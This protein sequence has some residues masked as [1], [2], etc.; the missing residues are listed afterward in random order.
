MS[1]ILIYLLQLPII[2]SSPKTKPR[3]DGTPPPCP[4]KQVED[5]LPTK[6]RQKTP[7]SLVRRS[8]FPGRMKQVGLDAPN[9][10]NNAIKLRTSETSQ[11]ADGTPCQV[12]N[13]SLKGLSREITPE[14]HKPQERGSKGMQTDSSNS[15]SSSVSIQAFELF[16]DA[17]TPF[18]D[19]TEQVLD[20]ETTAQIES[21]ESYLPSCSPAAHLHSVMAGNMR[22]E[23]H[24]HNHESDLCLVQTSKT[25]DLQS[26][27]GDNEKLRDVPNSNERF[28][29][30][31]DVLISR[32]SYRPDTVV[33]SKLT[34]TSSSSGDDKFTVRELLSSVAE[35]IPSTASPI[36][37]NQQSLQLD[38]ANVLQNSPIDKTASAH[39]PPAFD[40]VIHVI[41]HSS[42]RVGS[43]QPVMESVEMGVQN[44][45]VGKLIN[46]VRDEVEMRSVTSPATLKS[47]SCSETMSLKSNISEHS[48]AKETEIKNPIVPSVLNLDSSESTK[49]NSPVTDEETPAKEML[50]VK[51]SRQRAEALEGLLELSAELLQHNRLEELAVVLKPFGKDKVSPRETAIWLAKSL[52]GM[53]IEDVGRSS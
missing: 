26:T 30:K 45:D 49:T 6:T 18:I 11:Q 20:Q 19:M 7:P 4:V 22:R 14:P 32:P 35:A 43:E 34:C 9:A 44:V 46:V 42:F 29:C 2:D 39:L 17:T 21:A 33:Q 10:L 51:S 36:S 1:F 50:D 13:G 38:K 12:P 53:M 28:I 3:R 5:G 16:D 40:D 48:G 27:T 47:S 41:R 37:S 23:N 24:G 8:T 52:K 15:I 25:E 31:D